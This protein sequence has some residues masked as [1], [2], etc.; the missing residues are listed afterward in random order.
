[1]TSGSQHHLNRFWQIIARWKGL[2]V[3]F[4]YSLPDITCN[5]KTKP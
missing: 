5:T 2:E 3:D 1:M 4:L